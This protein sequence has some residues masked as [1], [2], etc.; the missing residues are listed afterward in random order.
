M[1]GAPQQDVWEGRHAS[2]H[3]VTVPLASQCS[4]GVQDVLV[5]DAAPG[6][7]AHERQSL[8]GSNRGGA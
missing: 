5:D 7:Q 8:Q 4:L 1:P 6:G 2:M 3:T